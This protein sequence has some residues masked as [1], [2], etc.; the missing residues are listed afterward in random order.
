VKLAESLGYDTAWITDTHLICRELWVTL[1]ACALA[2]SR[3]RLG[4]GITVPHTRHISVTASAAVT[5]EELAPGRVV[6]GVGT[7]GSAA[8][9]MGLTLGQTARIA[10][11]EAMAAHEVGHTLGFAHN[12]GASTQ[13]RPSVMDYP[14][15][16]VKLTGGKIDLSDAYGKDIGEWDRF[17]VDW[18][19]ADV[20]AGPTTRCGPPS[21]GCTSSPPTRWAT[22]WGSRTTSA[23]RR[24]GGPR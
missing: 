13:G 22:P 20:P 7:G 12:F 14:A 19:Y 17:L 2:T 8:Q 9:T 6:V 1:T 11:L 3:I 24:R 16:R 4:P 23:P 21:A 18:M 15:P 5:L 10:T